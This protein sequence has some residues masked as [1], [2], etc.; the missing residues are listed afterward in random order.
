M[1]IAHT[2]VALNQL[3]GEIKTSGKTDERRKEQDRDHTWRR[4]LGKWV[5]PSILHVW[6][7]RNVINDL[8]DKNHFISFTAD[9]AREDSVL[10]INDRQCVI[11]AGPCIDRNLTLFCS[12]LCPEQDLKMKRKESSQAT[13]QHHVCFPLWGHVEFKESNHNTR[14]QDGLGTFLLS[15]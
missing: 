2:P 13:V 5:Q 4:R 7:M 8:L 11:L 12:K 14:S 6:M 15:F 10:W 9:P 3:R 1:I